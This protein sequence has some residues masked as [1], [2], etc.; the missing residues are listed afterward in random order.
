M[1]SSIPFTRVQGRR[2]GS[3]VLGPMTVLLVVTLLRLETL[4][5][6]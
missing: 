6:G 2:R 1:L 4:K 5:L 3:R